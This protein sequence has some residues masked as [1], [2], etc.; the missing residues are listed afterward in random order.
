MAMICGYYIISLTY[1]LLLDSPYLL[2][3]VLEV[4]LLHQSYVI[5]NFFI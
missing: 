2:D 5:C 4:E 1:L 3:N